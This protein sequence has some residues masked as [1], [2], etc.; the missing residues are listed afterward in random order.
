MGILALMP[1]HTKH[2]AFRR[3]CLVKKNLR[4][5][6]NFFLHLKSYFF[7]EL[8]PH[9]KFQNPRTNPYV[10]KVS[11]GSAHNLLRPIPLLRL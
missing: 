8:K 3:M 4:I 7:G 11:K 9:A 1:A 2:S 10:R 5:T 6:P